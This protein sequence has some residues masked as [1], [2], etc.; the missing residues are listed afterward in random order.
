MSEQRKDAGARPLAEYREGEIIEGCY[1]AVGREVRTARNGRDFATMTL[2][3]ESGELKL[4]KFDYDSGRA[5]DYKRCNGV[6]LRGRIE[7]YNNRLQIKADWLEPAE[8]T[9]VDPEDL[10]PRT[11]FDVDALEGELRGLYGGMKNPWLRKLLLSFL[12]D[13]EFSVKFKRAPAAKHMH[14]PFRGGLIEHI[15]SV[16]RLS[17]KVCENYPQANPELLLAG[18]FLHDIG[19]VEELGLGAEI[20][21]TDIGVLIGHITIGVEMIEARSAAIEGFPAELKM[22]LKH[23]VLSH[24]GRLEYGSPKLPATLE[25]ILLHY[26]DNIDAKVWAY[27]DAVRRSEEDARFTDYVKMF[28]GRL[29]KFPQDPASTETDAE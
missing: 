7:K 29:Y 1:V 2:R 23:L 15:V 4:I 20:E 21:Y 16:S 12:D 6:N 22:M 14:H 8:L 10:L 13:E 24:H 25:A 11:A 9:D 5:A 18:V 19:K 27:L 3:D 26:V 17:L 28:E